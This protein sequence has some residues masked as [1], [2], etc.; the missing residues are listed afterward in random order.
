MKICKDKK[1]IHE[2]ILSGNFL[3]IG[4]TVNGEII[5]E[6]CTGKEI[7]KGN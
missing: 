2:L 1:K 6:K 5:I 4:I 7:S 3:I